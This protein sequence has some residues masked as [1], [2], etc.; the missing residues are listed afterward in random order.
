MHSGHLF[1][2]PGDE[3]ARLSLMYN[4]RPRV[5][6]SKCVERAGEE[7]LSSISKLEVPMVNRPSL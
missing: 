3:T 7:G 5:C 4:E 2:G 6:E 1:L